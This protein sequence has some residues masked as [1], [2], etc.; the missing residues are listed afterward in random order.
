MAKKKILEITLHDNGR[1]ELFLDMDENNELEVRRIMACIFS[2]M[3][4]RPSFATLVEF[5]ADIYRDDP[6]LIG[7]AAKEA[8]ESAM[9]QS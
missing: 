1:S 9:K 5:C 4:A 3:D 6:E 2:L 7:R 8:R